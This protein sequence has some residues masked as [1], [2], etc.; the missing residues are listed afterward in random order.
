MSGSTNKCSCK[1]S[2]SSE[3]LLAKLKTFVENTSVDGFDKACSSSITVYGRIFWSGI[4]VTSLLGMVWMINQRVT[5]YYTAMSATTFT[6]DIK[7]PD[8]NFAGLAFPSISICSE[9]FSTEFATKDLMLEIYKQMTYFY[10]NPSKLLEK[11]ITNQHDALYFD[12][13]SIIKILGYGFKR[14][15]RNKILG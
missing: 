5:E 3:I 6:T 11:V 1:R 7:T 15:L 10:E 9:A 4:L 14:S 2:L 8:Q 12:E 13:N